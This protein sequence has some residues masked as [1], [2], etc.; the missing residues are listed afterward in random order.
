MSKSV[1]LLHRTKELNLKLLKGVTEETAKART[2]YATWDEKVEQAKI[3]LAICINHRDALAVD[4][5]NKIETRSI[6]E[7]VTESYNKC[8]EI[9]KY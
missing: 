9:A 2:D 3:T 1:L 5:H 4:I 6:I 8:E 7:A